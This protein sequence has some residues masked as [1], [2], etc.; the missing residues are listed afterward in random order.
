MIHFFVQF[1]NIHEKGLN[2]NP[3]I[4]F[5]IGIS[6][7]IVEINLKTSHV[8]LDIKDGFIFTFF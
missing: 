2:I 1:E 5:I 4:R 8:H 3:K 6:E 7:T